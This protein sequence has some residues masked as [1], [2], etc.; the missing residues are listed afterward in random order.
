MRAVQARAR[1][2]VWSVLSLTLVFGVYAI[3][4]LGIDSDHTKMVDDDI[5]SQIAHHEFSEL[6]PILDEA[7]IVVID[8]V[9]PE[10]ANRAAE[11]LSA[12]LRAMPDHVSQVFEPGGGEFFARNG[13]LYRDVEELEELSDYLVRAQPIIAALETD[14]S[15]GNLSHLVR[16]GLDHMPDGDEASQQWSAVLDRVGE[17]T[18]AVYSEYPVHISWEEVFLRGSALD[19]QTRRVLM[20]DPVLDF[21]ALLP[22]G[23]SL[24][25]VREAAAELGFSPES[26]VT[27]R[28]TGNPALNHEEMIGLAWDIGMAGVFCFALVALVVYR[29]MRSAPLAVA[30][31][32]T[33]LA[34]LLWTAAFAAVAVGH[35]NLV[36]ICFAVL[37]IGLGI[38]FAIHLGTQYAHLRRHEV[39]HAE[40]LERSSVSVGSSL[41]VCTA[42]TAIGFFAFVPTDYRGVAELGLIAGT[43][44]F[45][46]LFMTL[47]LF[48]ALLSTWCR[49]DPET[50][51]PARLVL[52]GRA[53]GW[54]ER[55][56]VGVRRAALA[57]GI[58]GLALVPG[59]HFD[60]DVVK[61]R[62]PATESVQAFQ[63]LLDDN[64][65][66]SPW[67][68]NALAANLDEADAMA[69][70]FRALDEVGQVFT[71]RD[72]VPVDQEDKRE[73]L[74]DLSMM[75]AVPP[76][77]TGPGPA[78][79]AKDQIQ[80]LRDLRDFLAAHAHGQPH[81]PL[82]R[83]MAKLRRELSVFLRRVD[84]ETDPAPALEDLHTILL[85]QLP[86]QL[87]RLHQAFEPDEISVASL[88][89]SLS[90]RM[91][92]RDGRARVQ[93]FPSEK[94]NEPFAVERFV[95]AVH[96]V[97]D[98][99]TGLAV[100]LVSFGHVTVTSLTEALTV[101][102]AAIS[103]LLWFLWRR[104][105][106][107]LLVL[108]PLV[109]GAVLTVASMVAVGISFNF[110][111]VI[112]VPLLL[113]MGVD[114]GIHLVHRARS[115]GLAG[116]A[117]IETTTARAVFYSAV[118]TVVSFG[119]L[120]FSAHQGMAS[121][122]QLLVIGMVLTLVANLV[123]LP[124]L[125]VWRRPVAAEPIEG[126]TAP[127]RSTS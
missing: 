113:G 98:R 83:S 105:E 62:N 35:L 88:P 25:A 63:D 121:L 87:E 89:A 46:M 49:F 124:A 127:A 100:N 109:L 19:T 14:P 37:F 31:I 51:S 21:D 55:H 117:L 102:L 67:F 111:N 81:S 120:S 56:A 48:P 44:M 13:L 99:P 107:V 115:E 75:L 17:A 53:L 54:V 27:V 68:A 69:E 72:F 125:L 40:A 45:V 92:A 16:L 4:S 78:P 8:A 23:D 33:L 32:I 38:D 116:E 112:V 91:L 70:R 80:A 95:G 42:T 97:A 5:P 10:R 66:S 11:E 20:V 106:P 71:L 122:G 104:L 85:G 9:T 26:G 59:A 61:M 24:A 76:S 119:S 60:P 7:L 47:T 34:G 57:L 82:G 18:V 123:V 108:G 1:A 84:A 77:A 114:S 50:A 90:S 86:K 65:L 118:T 103:L 28:V 79:S 94:L 6:F 12:A 41:V 58:L 36:S 101:A 2:V 39:G 74:T 126:A 3:L 64:A 43:G 96:T 30:A 93:I 29:A 73:I 22:A 15:I 52:S 110:A